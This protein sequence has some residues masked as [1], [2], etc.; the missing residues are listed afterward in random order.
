M[1]GR[2]AIS[3]AAGTIAGCMGSQELLLSSTHHP[4]TPTILLTCMVLIQHHTIFKDLE[5]MKTLKVIIIIVVI[6]DCVYYIYCTK[7]IKLQCTINYC[8]QYT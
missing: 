6:T 1:K 3:A 7:V 5:T 4:T 2:K 8:R